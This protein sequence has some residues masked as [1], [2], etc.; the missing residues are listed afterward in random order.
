MKLLKVIRYFYMSARFKVLS[1]MQFVSGISRSRPL[2]LS[3]ST[4]RSKP[5]EC[6]K[7]HIFASCDSKYFTKFANSFVSSFSKNAKEHPIHIHICN[8]TP[9]VSA[10]AETLEHAYPNFSWSHDDTNLARLRNEDR[11][12][13]YCSVRFVRMFEFFKTVQKPC[14]CLDID[15]FCN[16]NTAALMEVLDDSDLAFF[17]RFHK[18]G[19]ST[20][21]LAGTLFVSNSASGFS[22]LTDVNDKLLYMI[23][24]GFFVD[25]IDQVVIYDCYQKFRKSDLKFKFNHL[26]DFF[27]MEF[28]EQGMIWYPKGASKGEIAYAPSLG[29][30]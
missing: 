27:D 22:F 20:K 18:L 2:A 6:E 26:G 19:N 12:I 9:P 16:Q 28:T 23:E 3:P 29:N 17:A 24:H 30:S 14:L 5:E 4:Y 13:Y 15:V 1:R 7:V 11:A 8:P 25:K 10:L 21:L